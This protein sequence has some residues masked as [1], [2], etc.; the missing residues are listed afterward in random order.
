[1]LQLNLFQDRS[2]MF[3]NML[4]LNLIQ[5]SWTMIAKCDQ[6]NERGQ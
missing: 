4:E 6:V 5:D 2:A 1:M 3:G